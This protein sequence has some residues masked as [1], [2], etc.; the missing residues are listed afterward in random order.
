M[1][2]RDT[3][4]KSSPHTKIPTSAHY[5]AHN[6]PDPTHFPADDEPT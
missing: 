1:N 2:Q 5:L 6:K 4:A 3:L